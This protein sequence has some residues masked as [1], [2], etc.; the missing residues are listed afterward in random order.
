MKAIVLYH[1]ES[2]HARTVTDYAR[3]Y[4]KQ[5]GRALELLSLET[6]AGADK[7]RVYDITQYPAVLATSDDGQLLQV[8]QGATLPLIREVGYYQS[9]QART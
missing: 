7:A 9:G 8:W 1:P 6:V 2:D 5:T 3:D 4:E